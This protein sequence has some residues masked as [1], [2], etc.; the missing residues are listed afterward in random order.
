MVLGRLH[1]KWRNFDPEPF[2]ESCKGNLA[3]VEGD[4]CQI[5]SYIHCGC[6]AKHGLRTSLSDGT[7]EWLILILIRSHHTSLHQPVLG[8]PL[9]DLEQMR[10]NVWM[11]GEWVG[12][13]WLWLGRFTIIVLSQRSLPT[14]T[15]LVLWHAICGQWMV[16]YGPY[17]IFHC[18][19]VTNV[20]L[21][22][23][24]IVL[25]ELLD[26]IA[27]EP[28]IPLPRHM[29]S[30]PSTSFSLHLYLSAVLTLFCTW[31]IHSF[32]VTG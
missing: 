14:G 21:N 17:S 23:L 31:P 15:K 10:S 9:N 29:L 27:S 26:V 16:K 8:E 20:G 2:L 19:R 3:S 30:L 4:H 22:G 5:D 1:G 6:R 11:D 28:P 25:G 12:W 24:T 18:N 13:R 32:I 7:V